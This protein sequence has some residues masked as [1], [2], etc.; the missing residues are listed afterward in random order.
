MNTLWSPMTVVFEPGVLTY[1]GNVRFSQLL[2]LL[3]VIGM[4][5][6]IIV[7]R[8]KGYANV[9]YADPIVSSKAIEKN[10]V[11]KDQEIDK[12]ADY[13]SNRTV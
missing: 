9:R 7:R 10:K 8:K 2:A 11:M 12:G 1:G 5:I 4:A 6:V 3:I 13:D